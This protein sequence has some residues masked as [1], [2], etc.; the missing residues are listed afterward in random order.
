MGGWGHPYDREPESV[1]DDVVNGFVSRRSAK[2]NYG[3]ILDEIG[4]AVDVE[5]TT[6]QRADR[7]KTR[8]F[9]QIEYKDMLA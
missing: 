1:L 5:A 3:V 6:R 8:L 2:A 7:P 4:T 9:H